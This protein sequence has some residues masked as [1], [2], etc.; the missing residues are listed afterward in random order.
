MINLFPFSSISSFTSTELQELRAQ[1]DSMER[2]RKN[3]ECEAQESSER[4]AEV[5]SQLQTV[6]VAKRKCDSE[7]QSLKV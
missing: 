2:A 5:T 1:L 3:A 6:S 7:I 4:L